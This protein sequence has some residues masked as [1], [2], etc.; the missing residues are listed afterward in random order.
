MVVED[1]EPFRR[2]ICSMLG[3]NPEGGLIFEASD[4]LEAVR[5]VE[6]LRLDIVLL[7]IGL[8][9]LNGIEVARRTRKLSPQSKIIFL[10]QES[11]DEVVQAAMSLGARG[12]VRKFAVASDLLPAIRAVCNG[13]LFVSSGLGGQILTDQDDPQLPSAEQP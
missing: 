12:Y 13:G 8:P 2:L 1:F 6:E 3:K 9:S 7:D 5:K 11:S 10:T 4:G